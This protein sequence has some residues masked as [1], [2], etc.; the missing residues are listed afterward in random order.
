MFETAE[1][2][3]AIDKE[4]YKR[5]EP[6]VREALLAAQRELP[7]ADFRVI[8][9][10]SGVETSGRSEV[11]NLLLKWMDA[12]GIETHAVREPTDEERERPLM[13]RFWRQLP[14]VGRMGIFFGGW[15]T[16]PLID[17]VLGRAG[18]LE[19]EQAVDRIADFERMLVREQT[20][21]VK[22]WLHIS[23][24]EQKRRLKRMAN[25]PHQRWRV[26]KRDR[27][28]HKLY[29]EFRHVAAQLLSHTDSA[30]TPWHI[31]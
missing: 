20:L 9:V 11:V 6:Q 1:I 31:V 30:E 15:Y 5:E 3:H 2:G 17:Q 14:R 25:D 8:V 29:D 13:W 19:L 4:T 21:L 7:R 26:T 22:F 28:H 12:R 18:P 24:H 10:V 23:K 16:P 27:R